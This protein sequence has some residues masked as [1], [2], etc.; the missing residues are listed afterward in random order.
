MNKN[1]AHPRRFSPAERT[2]LGAI[3]V[4]ALLALLDPRLATVPLAAFLL[5]CAIAPFVPTCSFFLPVISRGRSGRAAVALTFDDGPDPVTTPVL[6]DMLARY[7]AHAT[8]F[9]TGLKAERY[10]DLIRNILAS[11]HSI[12]NHSFS[13]DNCIMFKSNRVWQKEISAAQKVFQRFGVTPLA[14]RPPVGITN[15]RLARALSETDLFAVNFSRRAYD[16]GNRQVRHIS[17]RILKRLRPDDII[18]LHDSAPGT[19]AQFNRWRDEIQRILTG[20]HARGLQVEPLEKLIGRPVMRR[21]PVNQSRG[22]R[23]G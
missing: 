19:Q 1:K 8:F 13:H 7:Q 5:L 11:G 21:I 23:S 15:P 9:T 12:G 6:L 4:A 14:F 18:M 20:I 10:P 2:G 3:L 22:P 16:R 17:R